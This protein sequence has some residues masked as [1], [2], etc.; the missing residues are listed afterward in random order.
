MMN[1]NTRV[2]L[3]FACLAACVTGVQ[4]ADGDAIAPFFGFMG[5]MASIVFSC[6][7]LPTHPSFPDLVRERISI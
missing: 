7:Y 1:T 4:A 3:L 6:A 2:A 5:A